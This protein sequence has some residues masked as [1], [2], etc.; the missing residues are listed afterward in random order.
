MEP[1]VHIIAPTVKVLTTHPPIAAWPATRDI[2][3]RTSHIA[4]TRRIHVNDPHTH[5][6]N[7][8]PDGAVVHVNEC[9]GSPSAVL[10]PDPAV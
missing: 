6:E 1:E 10:D 9:N 5:V 2:H 3:D 4:I 8:I 7:L